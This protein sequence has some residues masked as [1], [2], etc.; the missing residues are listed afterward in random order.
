M[1]VRFVV[2]CYR[3]YMCILQLVFIIINNN[4]FFKV[5]DIVD[6]YV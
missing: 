5:I 2:I 6:L 3:I 4:N 1:K